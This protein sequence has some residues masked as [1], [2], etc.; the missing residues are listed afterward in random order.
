MPEDI[1]VTYVELY[2][3]YFEGISVDH[4]DH[5]KCLIL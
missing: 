4:D 1:F 2:A 3:V 5:M